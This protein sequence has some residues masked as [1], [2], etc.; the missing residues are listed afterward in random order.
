MQ[1][2][3]WPIKPSSYVVPHPSS[4]NED[5]QNRG[6]VG[7]EEHLEEPPRMAVPVAVTERRMATFELEDSSHGHH[8]NGREEYSIRQK[9]VSNVWY[10]LRLYVI[11]AMIGWSIVVVHSTSRTPRGDDNN[12]DDTAE[13]ATNE[14]F[15][16]YEP[17]M[18]IC[19][20]DSLTYGYPPI[21]LPSKGN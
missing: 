5:V 12:L 19:Y 1:T 9:L 13:T 14:K 6:N 4:D 2:T 17:K 21:R 10:I 15:I 8:H 16:P 3:S 20:G 11:M 18:I 7:R